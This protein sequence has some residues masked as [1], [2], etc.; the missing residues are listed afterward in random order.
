[1][2]KL[3]FYRLFDGKDGEGKPY[4]IYVDKKGK[5]QGQK[6]DYFLYGRITGLRT[7]K[8]DDINYQGWDE[9]EEEYKNNRPTRKN[10][11]DLHPYRE[12]RH[13]QGGQKSP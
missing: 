9:N 10:H 11:H 4:G 3:G 13:P 2:E 8:G 12:K 1:M 5:G 7:L 6:V